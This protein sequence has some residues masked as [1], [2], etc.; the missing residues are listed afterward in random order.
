MVGFRGIGVERGF[1]F[2]FGFRVSGRY[3]RFVLLG[4]VGRE[5]KLMM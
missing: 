1:F 2:Y 5:G 3:S 4:M